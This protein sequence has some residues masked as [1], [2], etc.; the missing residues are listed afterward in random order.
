MNKTLANRNLTI[1]KGKVTSNIKKPKNEVNI[2][3]NYINNNNQFKNYNN[4]NQQQ[5]VS[6]AGVGISKSIEF[7]NENKPLGKLAGNNEQIT[8]SSD[9]VFRVT[10]MQND[11][12]LNTSDITQNRTEVSK[13]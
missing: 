9:N 4:N 1:S 12:S 10:T 6:S 2:S 11:L 7:K 13:C 3:N 8:I 5:N